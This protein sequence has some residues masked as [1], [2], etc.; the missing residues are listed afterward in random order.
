MPITKSA[1]KALRQSVRRKQ[2]NLQKKK[3]MKTLLKEARDLI[4]QKKTEEARKLLPQIYKALDK[5]AKT[6]VIKKNAASR[7][8]SRI[9]K[10]LNRVISDK[11]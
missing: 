7:K 2:K 1:K 10:A 6:G 8:K 5:T 9:T 3:K 4:G 11:Q